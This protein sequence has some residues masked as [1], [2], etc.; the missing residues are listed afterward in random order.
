MRPNP[1]GREPDAIQLL[2]HPTFDVWRARS[3][4]D[5]ALPGA[6]V[7][8]LLPGRRA[9]WSTLALPEAGRPHPMAALRA[10]LRASARTCGRTR[11]TI[12]CRLVGR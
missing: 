7:V 5:S 8:P 6:P 11:R 9:Q 12:T 10:L 3:G 4:A 1:E 2:L